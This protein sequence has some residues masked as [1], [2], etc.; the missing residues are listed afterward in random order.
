MKRSLSTLIELPVVCWVKVRPFTLIEL[1]VAVPSIAAP[2]LRGATER[3]ARFTLIELLVVIAIISILMSM[4]LPA[5]SKAKEVG[6]KIVCKN[7]LKQIGSAYIHYADDYDCW[8]PPMYL[9]TAGN[10]Y[11]TY[12]FCLLTPYLG[13]KNAAPGEAISGYLQQPGTYNGNDLKIFCCP[14]GINQW[15]QGSYCIQTYIQNLNL[16]YK[17]PPFDPAGLG[18]YQNYMMKYTEYKSTSNCILVYDRWCTGGAFSPPYAGHNKPY[19]RN[20]VYLDQHVAWL[21]QSETQGGCWWD[22]NAPM[23]YAHLSC[24]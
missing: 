24:Y 14:S 1:L 16:N 5:L 13:I 20:F 18:A 10:P 12:G 22:I 6:R 23:S 9:W 11:G 15:V 2:R 4:L 21:N 8:M 19:G 7:N 3:V 17:N